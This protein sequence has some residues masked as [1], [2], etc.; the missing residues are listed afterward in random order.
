[1]AKVKSR[2][3]E[4]VAGIAMLFSLCGP[5]LARAWGR[6]GA[7]TEFADAHRRELAVYRRTESALTDLLPRCYGLLEDD[8]REAY[9]ILMELLRGDG[10]AW[11][12][13]R[14]DDTPR[15][16]AAVHGHWLGRDQELLAE[17]WLHRVPEPAYL[18]KARELWE[19]LVRHAA[20]ELPELLD[21]ARAEILFGIIEDAGYWT[22][23]LHAMPRTLVHND[24]NPRNIAVRDGRL[25]VFDWELATVDVPQRDV[26][27]LLAFTLGPDVTAAEVD[28]FLA[29]HAEAV[30]AVSPEAASLVAGCDWHRGYQLALR[31]FLMTRLALYA[32]GHSQREFDFLPQ[33]TATAFRLWELERSRDGE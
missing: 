12:R 9:I 5:D 16:V 23:E 13:E 31:E 27:E 15:A 8:E 18:A 26:V 32:A 7:D 10:G 33:V 28:R 4:I 24:L 14:V 2:G 25:V 29:V 3:Q 17:D 21:S 1:M 11:T 20:R 30:A 6:W 22:Q 19:A